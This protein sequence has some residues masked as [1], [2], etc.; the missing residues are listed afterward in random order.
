MKK[1]K[2]HNFYSLNKKHPLDHMP[3]IKKRLNWNDD[4]VVAFVDNLILISGHLS[5]KKEKNPIQVY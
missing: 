3:E 2:F 4:T 5:S 1:E